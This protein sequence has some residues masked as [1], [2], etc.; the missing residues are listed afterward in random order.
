MDL[1]NKPTVNTCSE[2]K[3]GNPFVPL[4]LLTFE[5][6]NINLHNCLVDS[7]ASSNVIPLSI[8][9]KLNTIPLKSDKHVIQID[10]T[11]MKFMGEHKD[12]M[13]RMV[14]HSEFFQVIDIIVIDIPE[15]CGLLL[16]R[17]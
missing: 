2:D 3:K 11:Q 5:V 8:C 4:F 15:S 9:R 17:D 16:S 14:K 10:K 6:F 1:R 7:R 13:I 12:V